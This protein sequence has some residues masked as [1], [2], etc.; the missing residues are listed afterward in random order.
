MAL[1]GV[2]AAR[3]VFAPPDPV[4]RYL[5]RLPLADLFLDTA[6]FGAH[7]TVNDALFMGVP[8]VTMAGRS[9]AGRASASQV[10]A[11]GMTDLVAPD[12]ATYV[13]RARALAR[14]RCAARRRARAAGPREG[15]AAVRCGGLRSRIWRSV[16]TAWN[17]KTRACSR[18]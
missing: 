12:L 4:E 17:A 3:L 13:E 14:D 2:D 10:S 16:V 11:A 6:P 9:F 5:A 7:T 18:R 8:V 1:A 15:H